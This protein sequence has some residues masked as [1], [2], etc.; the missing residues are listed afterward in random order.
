MSDAERQETAQIPI[1]EWLRR[2][3][4]LAGLAGGMIAAPIGIVLHELGHFTVNVACGFPDTVLRYASVSWTGSGEFRR[5][6]R[7]GDVEAAAAIAEPWQVA[8]SAAAGPLI[9]YLTAIAFVLW[10]RRYGPGPLSLVLGSGF[11]APLQ[12]LAAIPVIA[13]DLFGGGFTGNQDEAN[14]AAITGIPASL[15]VLPGLACL[16]LGYW[17]LVTAFPRGQRL[18]VVV[19]PLVGVALGIALWGSVLGPLVLP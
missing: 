10:V 18:R 12:G 16:L 11:V 2:G 6:W 15:A 14:F 8:V 19:P 9:S 1:R 17:F 4:W 5:L 3:K 7:E 13:I